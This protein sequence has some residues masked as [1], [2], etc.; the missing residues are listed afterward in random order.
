PNVASILFQEHEG[1]FLFGVIDG[2]MTKTNT[3]G[4]VFVM[5]LPVIKRFEAGFKAGVQSVNP[6]AKVDALYVGDLNSVDKGKNAASTLYNKNAVIVFHAAGLA[7]NGVF[8]EAKE[9]KKNGDDVCVIGV[10]MDQSLT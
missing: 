1:S 8:T 3:I 6:N 5:E 2:S 9:R 7:G 4:F 10:D